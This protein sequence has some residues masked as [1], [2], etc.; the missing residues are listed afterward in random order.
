MVYKKEFKPS[1]DELDALRKGEVYDRKLKELRD[2]M[3]S[4]SPLL[5][6][7]LTTHILQ[8]SKKSKP[9]KKD[10]KFTP[11]SH[12]KLK[13]ANITGLDTA[14]EAAKVAKPNEQFGMGKFTKASQ[15]LT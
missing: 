12:Y 9:S 14:E 4:F 1:D 5:T 6:S 7:L 13:Y 10:D 15:D 11:T 8:E 2:R 3:V